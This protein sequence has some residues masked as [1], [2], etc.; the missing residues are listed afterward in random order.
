MIYE[1]DY[2]VNIPHFY[3]LEY[4]EGDHKMTVEIDLRDTMPALYF[5]EIKNWGPPHQNENLTP[6][7]KEQILENIVF[8][9]TTVKNLK[10]EVIM[11][12]LT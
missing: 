8:F 1:K 10:I 6:E 9:L 7:K 5:N 11:D 4:I 3:S 2:T 12:I